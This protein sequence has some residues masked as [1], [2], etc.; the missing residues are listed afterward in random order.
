MNPIFNRPSDFVKA[1]FL[2]SLG[3]A[4]LALLALIIWKLS[5]AALSIIV[6]FALGTMLAMLFDP[7]VDRLGRYGI[8]RGFAI[9]MVFSGFVLILVGIGIYGVPALVGQVSALAENGPKYLANLQRTANTF[10]AHHPKILGFTLPRS[11]DA[12]TT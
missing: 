12:L 6:P 10:L 2:T 3:A 1:G 7:V 8:S 11:A 9:F 5:G 4:L